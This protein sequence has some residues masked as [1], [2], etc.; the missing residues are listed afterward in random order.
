ML[1]LISFYVQLASNVLKVD[2][3]K[4]EPSNSLSTLSMELK[5]YKSY[6]TIRSYLNL[7]ESAFHCKYTLDIYCDN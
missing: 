7:L 2:A 5:S 1:L 3:A 4:V 6:V